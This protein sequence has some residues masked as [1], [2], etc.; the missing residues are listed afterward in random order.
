M[1]EFPAL[2]L[3]TD[4]YLADTMHLTTEEHGVYLLLLIMAWRASDTS[5]P[6]DDSWISNVCKIHG[7]KWRKMKP[8]IT[9]FWHAKDGRL[10]QKRLQAEREFVQETSKKNRSASRKRWDDFKNNP[11][12]NKETGYANAMPNACQTYAPTPTPTPTPTKKG[13]E[14]AKRSTEIPADWKPN[15]SHH[16]KINGSI[17]N[18][19]DQADRFR[20]YHKAKG[21]KFVNWDDA[22]HNWITKALEFAKRDAPPQKPMRQQATGNF[23]A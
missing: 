4:A 13:C 3:F 12:N 22:F 6:D 16:S 18:V 20:N 1:A 5:I 15:E 8:T 2:P 10:Y 14:N 7:N 9:A 21:N 19:I 11:L 23:D 17:I